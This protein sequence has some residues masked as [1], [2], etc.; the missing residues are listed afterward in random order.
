LAENLY[1][2]QC[3]SLRD[4]Q[5]EFCT[6]CG[7]KLIPTMRIV[8]MPFVESEQ[9]PESLG[10][11]RKLVERDG[12]LQTAQVIGCQLY[13]SSDL[14]QARLM[15]TQRD[16]YFNEATG[17]LPKLVKSLLDP[18]GF[19]D[20]PDP[21]EVDQVTDKAANM[22]TELFVLI[23]NHYDPE[24]LFLPEINYYF[25]R[26]PR[27]HTLGTGLDSGFGFV[28]IS[29]FL[30]DNRENRIVSRGSG[31]GIG[32]FNSGDATLDENFTISLETQM[33]IMQQAGS[34]AVEELLKTMKMT[35]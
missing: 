19:Y 1:C 25:F 14:E 23:Q 4:P 33:E 32:A 12:E 10:N 20:I 2:P 18:Q 6:S 3:R 27:L 31:T 9:N 7:T 26:Y 5:S 13:M 29:A 16:A 24:Y 15:I 34:K 22:P 35:K 28:Q 30:L 8:I 17:M 11:Y 21:H